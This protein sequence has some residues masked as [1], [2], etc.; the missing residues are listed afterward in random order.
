MSAAAGEVESDKMMQTGD[1][2]E[3]NATM[4][5]CANCGAAAGD[6]IKLKKCN[7][8]YLVKYCS[9]KC[10]REHR[11]QHKEECKKRAAELRDEV[12][13]RQPESSHFGDCPICCLPLPLEQKQSNMMPCCGKIICD[14]CDCAEK[15]RQ[16][17]RILREKK[18][19]NN[20]LNLQRKDL[21][22]TCL[23][24]RSLVPDGPADCM[25][26][27]T[28]RVKANDSNAMCQLG[29]LLQAQGD[30]KNAVNNWT[31]SAALGNI[32]AHYY[33]SLMYLLGHGVEKNK[34]KELHHLQEAAIGGHPEARHNLGTYESGR[35]M[36]ERAVKHFTIATKLGCD[37]SAVSLRIYYRQGLVS[38]DDF[39]A[40]LREHQASIDATKSPQREEAKK[41][42]KWEL[43][44]QRKGFLPRS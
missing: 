4:L 30:Y 39:E 23:F 21:Q 29:G 36:H 15:K 3:T 11:P 1:V 22:R 5:C 2:A 9:V 33:L 10:Q 25:N 6:D 27:L 16:L 24:C 31:K 28:K 38:K 8:C 13:F 14:G 12:L 20:G 17:E 19:Q 42:A 34:K 26:H 43:E 7:G 18:S 44:Y 41:F 32:T 37:P 35:G 40:A